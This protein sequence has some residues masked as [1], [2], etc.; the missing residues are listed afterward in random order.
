MSIT[1]PTIVP[2]IPALP[3]P[4]LIGEINDEYRQAENAWQ[5]TAEHAIRCGQL[6]HQAKLNLEHGNWTT[7]LEEN[8]AGSPRVAQRYMQ[9]A[10]A[11]REDP[12][13]LD[14]VA[15]DSISAAV[16]TI[17]RTH[18]QPKAENT[19]PAPDADTDEATFALTLDQLTRLIHTFGGKAPAE[20]ILRWLE[21]LK[22]PRMTICPDCHHA[23]IELVIHG[24]VIHAEQ[25][26][27][28]EQ[29]RCTKCLQT[30]NAHPDLE[31]VHCPHCNNTGF[32]GTRKRPQV[33]MLAIDVGWSDEEEEGELHAR[34]I[35]PRTDRRAGEA[36]HPLHQCPARQEQAA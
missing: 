24:T 32:T 22:E 19:L 5:R 9:L 30:R 10:E 15:E 35:G 6:L 26:S 14:Q 7:W 1:F 33:P 36:L 17:A 18:R 2:A 34:I 27:W 20:K 29:G 8:F 3:A 12:E 21:R 23:V 11:A 13:L 16:R 25:E 4:T 31:H 28:L